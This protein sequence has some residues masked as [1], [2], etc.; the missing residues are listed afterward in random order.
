MNNVK[1]R[2]QLIAPIQVRMLEDNIQIDRN[3]Y[4]SG[5]VVHLEDHD[6][7]YLID[8]GR[9]E[10]VAKSEKVDSVNSWTQAEAKTTKAEQKLNSALV[11]AAKTS[12]AAETVESPKGSAAVNADAVTNS[13]TK[14]TTHNK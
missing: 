9:A 11:E 2:L 12:G 4:N 3:V 5:D 14:V 8:R 1:P 10:A 6:A 7:K 13:N